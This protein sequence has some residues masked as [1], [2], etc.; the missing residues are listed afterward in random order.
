M[1]THL[2]SGTIQSS[3]AVRR[4]NGNENA[5][6]TRFR[7]WKRCRCRQIAQLKDDL[8]SV[9]FSAIHFAWPSSRSSSAGGSS[10]NTPPRTFA[11]RSVILRTNPCGLSFRL[12]E[13]PRPVRV[14]LGIRIPPVSCVATS[15]SRVEIRA[16]RPADI[17]VARD[18][19]RIRALF[20]HR[21]ALA[22]Y[23]RST[24]ETQCNMN[25]LRKST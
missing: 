20:P 7:V 11:H 21:H 10:L 1:E 2:Q 25:M 17:V 6:S 24:K 3:R 5:L 19:M 4:P 16:C 22:G 18:C 15:T 13:P 14:F 8:V 23:S 9:S 12:W